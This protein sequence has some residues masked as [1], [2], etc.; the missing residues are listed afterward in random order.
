MFTK[1]LLAE[2]GM[3]RNLIPCNTQINV[4]DQYDDDQTLITIEHVAENADGLPE[5]SWKFSPTSIRFVSLLKI[6]N[7]A[8]V[9]HVHDYSDTFKLYFPS[10]LHSKRFY[11]LVRNALDGLESCLNL[12]EMET[13]MEGP[14]INVSHSKLTIIVYK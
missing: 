12:T 10:D 14:S 6:D 4:S 7:R 9:L 5:Q 1:V 13:K 3:A 11:E 2:E 8:A